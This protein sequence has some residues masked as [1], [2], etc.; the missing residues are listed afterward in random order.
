MNAQRSHGPTTEA[1]KAKAAQNSYKHGFF[2]L[3]LFPND[4]LRAQ[5]AADYNM[6]YNRLKSHYVPVGFMEHFWLEKIA[7]E[8]LRLNRVL[9]YGQEVLGWEMA[10]ESPSVDR[11]LRYESTIN[12]N[13]AYAVQ[14]LEQLQAKRKEAADQLDEATE[15]ESDDSAKEPQD[16]PHEPSP[17]PQDS[18]REEPTPT[19]TLED[20]LQAEAV[21]KSKVP[22]SIETTEVTPAHSEP[23]HQPSEAVPCATP[24]P[25]ICE[26]NPSQADIVGTMEQTERTATDAQPPHQP[27][28]IVQSPTPPTGICETDSADSSHW[29]ET[30]KDQNYIDELHLEVYGVPYYGNPYGDVNRLSADIDEESLEESDEHS[31]EN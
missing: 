29:V 21:G 15:P 5:D 24:R 26:P 16:T 8:S 10:F 20:D 27:T 23:P 28:E 22:N 1:G 17:A 4:K 7:T 2:A 11:L 3:R 9:G 19:E 14:T 6:V 13:F 25:G 31:P 30:E 18:G 12:R